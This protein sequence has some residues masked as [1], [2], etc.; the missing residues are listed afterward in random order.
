MPISLLD[1]ATQER[2]LYKTARDNA[3]THLGAANTSLKGARTQ[4]SAALA[5]LQQLEEQIAAA[6]AKLAV[7]TVP[8]NAAEL[9]EELASLTLQHRQKQSVVLDAQAALGA[10]QA[11]VAS[12]QSKLELAARRLADAEAR[13]QKAIQENSRREDLKANVGQA[14][15]VDLRTTATDV[16]S[17]GGGSTLYADAQAKFG[18]AVI[19]AKLWELASQRH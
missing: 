13:R 17:G 3:Q 8:S 19:P 4:L 18:T 12:A 16:L 11:A 2:D 15:L 5:Q 7:T 1:F 10:A 6:R 9:L 14:P